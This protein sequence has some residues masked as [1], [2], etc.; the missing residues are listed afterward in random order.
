[1]RC[2]YAVDNSEATFCASIPCVG[3]AIL[4][5]LL[6]TPFAA[7]AQQLAFPGAEGFG[8]YATGGRGG[9]VYHVT[10]LNDSGDGSFRDAV[11]Q[12]NRT[13]VFD[14]GGIINIVDRIVV[15]NNVTI[16]GQTSPGDGIVIYGN[17]MSFSNAN[18]SITRYIRVRMG[19]NG[20]SDKDA[21]TI[22]EGHDMIFDHV[23]VSWGRDETFS[24]SGSIQNVTMQDSII[25]QGLDPHSC[26][27]LIETDGGVSLLRN[28][29]ID[30][31]TRNPKVKG[32]NEF[33]NNLVY[34]WRVA[35]YILGD[36]EGNSYA[37]VINNYFIDGPDTES[38]AFTRGNLNFHIY[39]SNNYQ[40]PNMNGIL[41]GEV[42]PQS[43]YGIVDWQSS[44]Y[45]YP[46]VTMLSPLETYYVVLSKA[47]V[48][49]PRDEVDARL[50]TELTS[51]GTLGQIIAN[52]NDPPMNGPGT[53][54]SGT[55]ATDTDRDGMP[56]MWET[57]IGLDPNSAD[58]NGDINGNSYTNLEDYLN[59]LA[60][61]HAKVVRNS[62][63]D[64]DLRQFSSGFN[65][66]ASYSLSDFN[67]G[68]AMLLSDGYTARFAPARGYLG[69]ASFRYTVNNGCTMT[70]TVEVL[71]TGYGDWI[72]G[73]FT[74]DEIVDMNDMPDFL[75]FWLVDDCCQTEEIDLDSNCLVNFYEFSALA[76]NWL[77]PP[78]DITAPNAPANL[79]ASAGNATVA[80]DWADNNESDLAG[81][82]LYCSTTSGGSYSQLNS[83]L[84]TNSNYT[85]NSVIN[86]TMYYYVVTAVD[87]SENESSDSV[88]ACAVPGI[89][90]NSITLQEHATGFCNVDGSIDND[91]A[92]YTGY[93]FANTGN[94]AGNGIDWRIN[95][96]S[97]SSYT[98]KWRYANGSSD[99]PAR[100]LINGSEEIP[101]ISFPGT[102]AWTNWSEVS[103]VVALTAGIKDIRLEATGSSGLANIDYLMVTSPYPQAASCP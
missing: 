34:N 37:N 10:N 90:G 7:N 35:A 69:L 62:S 70:E 98:F 75:A 77:K 25:S 63:V 21:I 8:R 99:R 64:I 6:A 86:G 50:I 101:S 32:V 24:V 9:S 46:I 16:A 82:N 31:N 22:A 20:T 1:M 15:K 23:S 30:N 73:D 36:S 28:L 91:N 48:S 18:N 76:D 45:P 80:L 44:P 65:P 19:I 39:A 2:K 84:L 56:D 102:G 53:V 33:I 51:L 66:G 100:M 55:V 78:A 14:V 4:M 27:G 61:P 5:L 74:G 59:W 41:D 67:H 103:V 60:A 81:Y 13:V 96:A 72:Y 58:N 85:D 88:E 79:W 49:M 26:G 68:T 95:I 29:Y 71:V 3:I 17:G 89:D 97:A 92:G 40:D 87:T 93:G 12:S 43:A 57:A 52:E 94:A 47:G 42:I 38:A 11:S 54:T 83:S